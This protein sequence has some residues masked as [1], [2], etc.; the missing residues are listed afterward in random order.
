MKTE[1]SN[2][3]PREQTNERTKLQCGVILFTPKGVH[4]TEEQVDVLEEMLP[5]VQKSIA[6]IRSV[7]WN[8][9]RD[10]ALRLHNMVINFSFDNKAL[11]P[12]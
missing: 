10:D 5:L 9:D 7:N 4:P 1:N 8:L 6:P 12:R 3:K 11:E 2:Y